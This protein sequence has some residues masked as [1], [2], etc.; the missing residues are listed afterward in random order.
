MDVCPT[1]AIADYKLE[2]SACIGCGLCLQVCRSN[3]IKNID[4]PTREFRGDWL[5]LKSFEPIT[6]K[7]LIYWCIKRGIIGV[8]SDRPSDTLDKN[9]DQANELL[10]SKNKKLIFKFETEI[11]IG[12]R[13]LLTNRIDRGGSTQY[14][15]DISQQYAGQFELSMDSNACNSCFACTR[16]CEQ[17]AL[18]I[19][20]LNTN[21]LHSQFVIENDLCNGCNRCVAICSRQAI[22]VTK[23][24]TP[25]MKPK[26][27]TRLFD[28]QC[29][30]CGTMVTV[31]SSNKETCFICEGNR[32]EKM[33]E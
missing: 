29:I 22:E 26:S 18:R 11:N 21:T 20:N 24:I 17:G 27:I 28:M 5:V 31:L 3:A 2:P 8:T 15:M 30:T 19:E 10:S 1:G 4:M 25:V 32:A 13:R 23:A 7:E 14:K 12:K 16:V 33:L 6:S 9:I